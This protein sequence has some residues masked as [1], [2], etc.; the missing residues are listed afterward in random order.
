ML[1]Q[2]LKD[3]VPS[4]KENLFIF[5]NLLEPNSPITLVQGADNV[6]GVYPA[7]DTVFKNRWGW[8]HNHFAD[9]DSASLIFSAGDLNILADQIIRDSASF[10]LDYKRFMIGVVADSNTQYVLMVDDLNKF[11]TWANTFSN[12]YLISVSYGAEKLSQASLPLSVAETEKRFLK[13]IQN[14]GLKLFRGSSDFTTWTP[15]SLI[16]NGATVAAIPCD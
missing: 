16:R 3:E 5:N 10:H 7:V 2:A 8:M 6:F 12:E 11:A 1:F 14:A 9:E 15:L 4:R 13:V